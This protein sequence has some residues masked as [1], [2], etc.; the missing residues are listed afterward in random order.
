MGSGSIVLI[1]SLP[2]LVLSGKWLHCLNSGIYLTCNTSLPHYLPLSPFHVYAATISDPDYEE[3]PS[4]DGTPDNPPATTYIAPTTSHFTSATQ[5]T[6]NTN[7]PVE[8][9][10]STNSN[11]SSSAESSGHCF[12][13]HRKS[14]SK[15][16]HAEVAST[17]RHLKRCAMS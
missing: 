5:N 11:S 6:P 3:V 16:S 7:G 8:G 2:M 1:L 12:P 14:R 17:R 13:H 4:G 10:P 9:W 15:S